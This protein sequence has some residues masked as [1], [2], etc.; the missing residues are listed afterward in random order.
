M[1]GIEDWSTRPYDTI[2]K[3][4]EDN[5]GGKHDDFVNKVQSYFTERLDESALS[6]I[7]SLNSTSLDQLKSGILVKYRCMVQDV[8]DPQFCVGQYTVTNTN[9]HSSRLEF[10]SFRDVPTLAPFETMECG[11]ENVHVER[12]G[13]YCVPIPG[14]SEWVKKAYS[15]NEAEILAPSASTSCRTKRERECEYSD[16][17]APPKTS[18]DDSACSE[19]EVTQEVQPSAHMADPGHNI[20]NGLPGSKDPDKSKIFDKN[21]PLPDERGVS[22]I[23]RVYT[24]EVDLKTTDAI[25]FIGI[26]SMDPQLASIFDDETEHGDVAYQEEL[27]AH[28]PPPSLVPRVHALVMRRLNHNN[29]ILPPVPTED[30]YKKAAIHLMEDALSL[31]LELLSILEHA[32]LCDRL[33]AEYLLCHLISTVYAR[34]DMLPLGKMCLNISGCPSAQKYIKFLHHLISQLTSQTALL[35]M[36]IENMNSVRLIPQKDYRL[37]RITAGMLQLASGTHLVVDETALQQGQLNHTGVTNVKALADVI[38]WQKVDYDFKWHPIPV[39]TNIH[40]LTLSEGES[41]LPKD[42]YVPLSSDNSIL[43]I[44]AHFSKLDHRLTQD[45]LD[46]IRS[47]ISVCKLI[48]YSISEDTQKIIQD[49][50]VNT[51]QNNPKDMSIE[52][53]QR[54]L[55]LIRVLTLSY[56]Q[57]SPTADLWDRVKIME[58]ERKSRISRLQSHRPEVQ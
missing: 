48:D 54:L 5:V 4:F 51:R 29:P 2:Q 18:R 25:E 15:K 12:H 44:P 11:K 52:D 35:E 31:R 57:C 56:G 28:E 20:Q 53:F 42:F 46:K 43:D 1:P 16:F 7:P 41:L 37:N 26:L 33:A 9:A 32:L 10:G 45:N 58:E 8:F 13:F 50:F 47:Y 30:V 3:L 34:A 49:D 21:L 19:M 14:E 27:Q 24:P 55:G 39:P 40:V 6:K 38:N 36:S 23:V 22:C 17:Q